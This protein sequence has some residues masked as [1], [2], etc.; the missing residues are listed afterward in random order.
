[1]KRSAIF[2]LLLSEPLMAQ[3]IV[4]VEAKVDSGWVNDM[5]AFDGKLVIGGRFSGMN[6]IPARNILAWDGGTGVDDL[7][8]NISG[9]GMGVYDVMRFQNG[10]VF[11]GGV[12]PGYRHVYFWNGDTTV[13]LGDYNSGAIRCFAEFNGELY[14]GGG[15]T[16]MNGDSI[17]R[18]AKWNGNTWTEVGTGLNDR[19]QAMEVYDG[20][21]FIGGVFTSSGDNS[22]ELMHIAR[23]DGSTMHAVDVALNDDVRKMIRGPDGL[24]LAGDFTYSADSSVSLQHF[25]YCSGAEILPLITDVTVQNL[26]GQSLLVDLGLHGVLAKADLHNER[27]FGGGEWKKASL[28]GVNCAAEFQG[29]TYVGGKMEGR[30]PTDLLSTDDG[31]LAFAKLLTGT[32][33]VELDVAGLFGFIRYDGCLFYDRFRGHADFTPDD[34]GY[35]SAIF[36]HGHYV[37]GYAGGI[38]RTSCFSPYATG[39]DHLPGVRC[40]DPVIPFSDRYQRTWPLDIGMLWDHAA[41][42]GDVGYEVPEVIASWPAHGNTANGEPEMIAPFQDVN[43]NGLYEPEQ[44]DLPS[45]VGDRAVLVQATD[46]AADGLPLIF[47]SQFDSRILIYGFDSGPD[48]LHQTLFARYTLTNRSNEL[49]DSVF[50]AMTTDADIGCADDDYV[51]CDPDLDMFYFYNWDDNDQGCSG[52]PGFGV[53]PPALGVVGLNADMHSFLYYNRDG[54]SCCNDPGTT[55]HAVNY[56]QGIWKDGSTLI[57]TVTNQVTRYMFSDYPDVV[58]GYHDG[59]QTSPDRRGTGSFGPFYD[60]A[61]GESICLD[62]AFVFARDTTQDHI[63]NTRVLQQK[64]IDLKEWYAQQPNACGAFMNVGINEDPRSAGGIELF[65]NPA[66]GMVTLRRDVTERAVV[67]VASMEGANILEMKWT[68]GATSMT[69][70]VDELADGLY[71]VT[72]TSGTQ[73]SNMLKLVVAR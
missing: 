70:P 13:I 37:V 33:H 17:R 62:V 66:S 49:Y 20:S 31:D 53:H 21:L 5:V 22:Q 68:A 58:G 6:G 12:L 64:V 28:P 34:P 24:W 65:P 14:A 38:G 3:R 40:D 44:G 7:G 30:P 48:A 67:R 73:G 46:M 4:P 15:F 71:L 43:G 59:P 60:V 41:H 23:W 52:N 2:L 27:V 45:I 1:M 39:R 54:P 36:S 42:W 69:L 19:V 55:D 56:A 63:Q 29:V 11:D 18:L 47:P 50:V 51:G 61:P 72:V 35:V 32:G 9:G 25:A 57:N 8:L 16:T 26:N 10:V